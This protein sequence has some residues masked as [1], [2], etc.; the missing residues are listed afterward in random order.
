MLPKGL[1]LPRIWRLS[2]AARPPAP[3]LGP[4]RICYYGEGRKEGRKEGESAFHVVRVWIG[5]GESMSLIG[6][7]FRL[8]PARPPAQPHTFFPGGGAPFHSFNTASAVEF[9]FRNGIVSVGETSNG[10]RETLGC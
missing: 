10:F 3:Q 9:Y 7:R 4:K 2:L 5:R 6:K 1:I 8:P